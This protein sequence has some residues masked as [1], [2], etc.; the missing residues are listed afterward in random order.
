MDET[1]DSDQCYLIGL[2][3]SS[4][5]QDILS[6]ETW[7]LARI[8]RDLDRL[9]RTG[10]TGAIQLAYYLGFR[11]PDFD[12]KRDVFEMRTNIIDTTY[13]DSNPHY[14]SEAK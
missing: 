8:F 11:H 10:F 2:I 7:E 9:V 5:S 12:L 1:L 13:I 6:P 14:G 3:I 4:H